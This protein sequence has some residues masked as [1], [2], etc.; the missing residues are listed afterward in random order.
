MIWFRSLFDARRQIKA[1]RDRYNRVRPHSALG[2][3]TPE[4]F[5][6]LRAAPYSSVG[7]RVLKRRPLAPHSH[8]RRGWLEWIILEKPTR[9]AVH[10]TGQ[11]ILMKK[12]RPQRIPIWRQP[13]CQ[14]APVIQKRR[15]F[16]TRP[17]VI[18]GALIATAAV[19]G[20]FEYFV[21]FA[22]GV[23]YL[24]VS[25][26]TAPGWLWVVAFIVC[27]LAMW[28]LPRWQVSRS[29]GL[30]ADNQFE[31]ENEAR[32]TIAQAFGGLLLLVG[33]YT[34]YQTLLNSREQQLT[35]RLTRSVDQLGATAS[36]GTPK[37]EIR[38]G[39]I[40]GWKGSLAIPT[41]TIGPF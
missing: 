32:K 13:C 17:W 11:I 23:Y 19:V 26:S 22:Y 24:W 5:A 9:T 30:T 21:G 18:V 41:K 35:D 1:W 7:G 38:L 16:W 36:D 8:P 12:D 39:G 27:L 40:Y 15:R 29:R 34:S 31:R 33:F 28:K 10:T 14:D 4:Q 37:Y 25:L 2:Y 3:R 6:A 20:A